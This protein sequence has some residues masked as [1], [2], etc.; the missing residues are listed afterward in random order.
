MTMPRKHM[1][2][3]ILIL[4]D[5]VTRLSVSWMKNNYKLHMNM[6]TIMTWCHIMFF[7]PKNLCDLSKEIKGICDHMCHL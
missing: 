7:V 3:Q 6:I 5:H 1:P 4:N 2:L